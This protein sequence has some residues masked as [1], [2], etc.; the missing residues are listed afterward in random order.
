M[1]LKHFGTDGIRGIVGGSITPKY[2]FKIAEATA[3]LLRNRTYA[4]EKKALVVL[5]CDTRLSCEY[6]LNILSGVLAGY[7]VDVVTVGVV[8][9]AALSFLTVNFNADLGIMISAS[10][11]SSLYNGCKFFDRTGEK[12]G[13]EKTAQLEK[14]IGKNSCEISAAASENVG[15]IKH[16]HGAARLWEKH[17][18]KT[19]K[20][21]FSALKRESSPE[22]VH[23][24]CAF[25]SGGECARKVLKSLGFDVRLH[26]TEYDGF[27]INRSSGAISPLS[28]RRAM[29]KAAESNIISPFAWVTREPNRDGFSVGF[30]FDGDADRCVVIDSDCEIVHGDVLLFNLA[31]SLKEKGLLAH[32]T[33]VATVMFNLGVEK[34]LEGE[35]IKLLRTP[36]GDSHVY[37]A[38]K[39][40][41]LTLGGETSG[42]IIFPNIWC[43]GDALL[44]ALQV[45]L[46]SQ[47]SGKAAGNCK[48][49][50]QVTKNISVTSTQKKEFAKNMAIKE[51]IKLIKQNHPDYRVIVRPSGTEEVIRVTVEG[52]EHVNCERLT[53]AICDKIRNQ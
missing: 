36:V 6:I 33:L 13:E 52:K 5:G 43:C 7:G 3:E 29:K 37:E 1:K 48:I 16:R 42:H 38:I 35:G 19:F 41:G 44:T 20:P 25:G 47:D 23:I 51:Y 45:L 17:L 9:S 46:V 34:A 15:A 26:N 22:T 11:N 12:L 31:K 53:A 50:P 21:F 24:D 28:L 10:H 8:P 39:K 32:N 40:H 2:I 27:N 49:Y 4:N 30:A 18:I 14:L